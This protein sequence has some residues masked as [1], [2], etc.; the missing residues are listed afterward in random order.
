MLEELDEEEVGLFVVLLASR[1]FWACGRGVVLLFN[2]DDP[3][4][5]LSC[6]RPG[7]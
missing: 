4:S 5:L 6:G 1:G 7:L 3:G 2:N